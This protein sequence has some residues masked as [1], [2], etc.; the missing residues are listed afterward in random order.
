MFPKFIYIISLKF[1]F[2][3]SFAGKINKTCKNILKNYINA[4]YY[5][6]I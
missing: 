4:T 2:V 6:K 5:N 3:N 1:A